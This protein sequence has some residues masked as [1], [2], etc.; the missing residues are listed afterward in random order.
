VGARPAGALRAPRRAPLPAAEILAAGW[1][2]SLHEAAVRRRNAGRLQWALAAAGA[3]VPRPPAD[4]T[5]GF[6]RLPVLVDGEADR[7]RASSP[8]ARRL[9]I[10][11]GYPRALCDLVG[12]R[13]RVA[14]ADDGFP[15]ARRLAEALF[16]LAT[17]SRL[18]EA[19][20]RRLEAWIAAGGESHAGWPEAVQPR[21]E[22]APTA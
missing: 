5:A 18:A 12:F 21:R 9:G 10:M 17:H 20:L 7:A 8:D 6:L 15:G 4:A 16:T 19:D 11:P 22:T 3:R 2:E 13:A 14:N 1:E